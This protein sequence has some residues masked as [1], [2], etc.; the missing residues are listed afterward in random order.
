[1]RPSPPSGTGGATVRSSTTACSTGRRRTRSASCSPSPP[2]P[3]SGSRSLSRS[4][5]T[6]P[7]TSRRSRRTAGSSRTRAGRPGRRTGT[8]TSSGA[9]RPRSASPRRATHGRAAGGSATGAPPTWRPAGRSWRRTPVPA[10]PSRWG[11]G[12]S[13]SRRWTKQSR[14]SSASTATMSA[15]VPQRAHSRRTSSRRRA[16]SARCSRRWSMAATREEL[17]AALAGAVA[18]ER[19]VSLVRRPH[20]YQTSHP[21]E[22]IDVELESGTRL[23]LLAKD[24]DPPALPPGAP[25][26]KPLAPEPERELHAYSEILEPGQLD[27]P[28]FFGSAGSLL[29]LERVQGTVLWQIGDGQVWEAVAGRLGRLHERTSGRAGSGNGPLVRF[30]AGLY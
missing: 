19:I 28:R 14:P 2:T 24:L 29:L 13:R 25:A 18:P 22:E 11:R 16:C 30:D 6:R 12:C 5:R 26:G 8:R 15:T 3:P 21:L 4:A 7:R 27:A 17:E 1:M 20:A 23:E 9:P 10:T